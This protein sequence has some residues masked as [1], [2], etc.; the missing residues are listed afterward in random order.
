MFLHAADPETQCRMRCSRG[1][2]SASTWA[3]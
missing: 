3:T 2:S 1:V